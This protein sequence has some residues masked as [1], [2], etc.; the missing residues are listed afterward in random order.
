[1]KMNTRYLSETH[2]LVLVKQGIFSSCG[3]HT[4]ISNSSTPSFIIFH[5]LP[6]V[7]AIQLDLV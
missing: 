2:M 5:Y 1:M 3:M 4:S 6:N 7:V